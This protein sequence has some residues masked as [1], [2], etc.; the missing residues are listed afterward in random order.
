MFRWLRGLNP[1][2]QAAFHTEQENK[3]VALDLNDLTKDTEV[4][5][6]PDIE[7]L[8]S[9]NLAVDFIGAIIENYVP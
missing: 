7:C 2:I 3:Q 5:A 4:L 9:S 8:T 1:V 6:K